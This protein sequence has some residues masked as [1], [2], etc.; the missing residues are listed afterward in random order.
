[1]APFQ[2]YSYYCLFLII[3]T[4][5][6]LIPSKPVLCFLPDLPKQR[7]IHYAVVNHPF[8]KVTSPWQTTLAI[9]HIVP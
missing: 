8:W 2:K 4:T 3:D 7:L 9:F 5:L 1:M 6:V